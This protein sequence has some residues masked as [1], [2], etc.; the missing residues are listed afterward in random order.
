MCLIS[1]RTF[2]SV[3]HGQAT[4]FHP[5]VPRE[6]THPRSSST[7]QSLD[8]PGQ[9][10]YPAPTVLDRRHALHH[11]RPPRSQRYGYHATRR[12]QLESSR[13][14]TPSVS[15]LP[16][17]PSAPFNRLSN[18]PRALQQS[19]FHA[20]T[21]VAKREHTIS[22][23]TRIARPHSRQRYHQTCLNH[24]S[25]APQYR[26]CLWSLVP[27]TIGLIPMVEVHL[28]ENVR[29]LA[30]TRMG[31]RALA[32]ACALSTIRLKEYTIRGSLLRRV[33]ATS[34]DIL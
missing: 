15:R 31:N 16:T 24:L 13:R 20:T 2:H 21:V 18:K 10:Y 28:G 14:P 4:S 25:R 17:R 9:F 27:S 33:A 6:S 8:T 1:P 7:L 11:G 23:P 19:T 3:K 12:V 5:A 32:V 30:V 26:V 34:L 29:G 22:R